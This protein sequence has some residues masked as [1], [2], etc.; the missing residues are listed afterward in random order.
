MT[1]NT[2]P[3][4]IRVGIVGVGNCANSLVQ[5]VEYYKN[6]K[7]DQEI[8]GLMHAVVGGYHINNVKFVAA[9]DVDEKK[10]GLDL[11]DAMWASENNTIK[12]CEVPKSGVIVE[13]GNTLD[14]LG[15]YYK[16]TIKESSAP[17]KIGRAHV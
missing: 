8:P 1:I 5:G 4:D 17:G 7:P 2:S 9:Y 15:R 6:A 11:A 13:R 10:V 16:E 14:G 12:F 3:K